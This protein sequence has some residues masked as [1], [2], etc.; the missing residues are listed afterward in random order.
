MLFLLINNKRT[1]NDAV[2]NGNI[3]I[4]YIKLRSIFITNNCWDEWFIRN[5]VVARVVLI[6]ENIVRSLIKHTS[7]SIRLT[8][9]WTILWVEGVQAVVLLLSVA[10][11][12]WYVLVD[13]RGLNHL[14]KIRFIF[15]TRKII[16]LTHIWDR[17]KSIQILF[18]V[19]LHLR[20]Y[21]MSFLSVL[22]LLW[23]TS[24]KLRL[25]FIWFIMIIKWFLL[26]LNLTFFFES[27][28]FSIAFVFCV[29]GF[30]F[31]KL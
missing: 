4:V 24:I 25:L 9:V 30:L 22:S 2:L 3:R 11:M 21:I 7:W 19:C 8:S 28:F 13:A 27:H 23:W 16:T 20:S 18:F 26:I 15:R 5:V 29:L 6:I 10:V 14:V 1:V 31:E 17:I 12:L